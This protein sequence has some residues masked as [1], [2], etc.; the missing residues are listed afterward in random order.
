MSFRRAVSEIL[1]EQNRLTKH[2][3]QFFYIDIILLMFFTTIAVAQTTWT[4]R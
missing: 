4:H 2:F 3:L 1:R